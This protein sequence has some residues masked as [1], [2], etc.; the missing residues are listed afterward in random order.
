M[1]SSENGCFCKPDV[2]LSALGQL[3]TQLR[4]RSL[5]SLYCCSDGVR[6][7]GTPMTNLSYNAS[8]HS[9]ERIAPSNHEIKHLVWASVKLL[10]PICLLFRK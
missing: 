7:R 6:G 2:E 10:L 3:F 5:R 4:E 8:F 9:F 1:L